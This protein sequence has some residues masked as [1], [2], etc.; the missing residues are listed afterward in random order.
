M[1]IHETK[2]DFC[3]KTFGHTIPEKQVG[4]LPGILTLSN[5]LLANASSTSNNGPK[6]S[7][8][9]PLKKSN[10][11]PY[12]KLHSD[13]TSY[14]SSENESIGCEKNRQ[15]SNIHNLD[16][17][18]SNEEETHFDEDVFVDHANHIRKR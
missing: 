18:I 15:E 12:E 2:S 6:I 1:S 3:D 5:N 9:Q 7:S 16:L 10:T 4:P 17:K 13:T 14:S 11:F 8:K